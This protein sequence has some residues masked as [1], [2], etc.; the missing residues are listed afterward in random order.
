[1]KRLILLILV[2]VY[3]IIGKA[4]KINGKLPEVGKRCP[5][6]LL[7]DVHYYTAKQASPDDF[8]GKWLILDFWN[9]SCTICLKSMPK[10]NEMQERRKNVLQIIM[11]GYTGTQYRPLAKEPDDKYIR[12]LFEINRKN[13]NLKLTVAYDST[14]FQR[15][16]IG[17]CPYLI[18]VSPDGIVKA[19]TTRINVEQVDSLRNNIPVHLKRAYTRSERKQL[20]CKQMTG[21]GKL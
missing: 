6:F 1:M 8:K 3:S 14:L 20:T 2:V 4:Q 17:P 21:G 7:N 11:V 13:E 15:F 9:R 18:V 10:M 16:D 19:I 5:D 12:K